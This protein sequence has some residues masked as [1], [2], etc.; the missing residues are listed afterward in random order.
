M[1]KIVLLLSVVL[2]VIPSSLLAKSFGSGIT[3]QEV[4]PI[5]AILDQPK[6]YVGKQ[7]K[8]AGL[9]VD[10]CAARGC[11]VYVAGER[12][13][14]KIRVKVVDG[15]I[16]FPM[17]ARGRQAEVE[18]IVEIFELSKEEVIEQRM[19]HALEQGEVFDPASVTEGE[20]VVR[21]RGLGAEIP[22]L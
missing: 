10:V 11:W 13:F 3:V 4:T 19:H 22:G 20:T 12:P 18:G 9:I 5:S 7:V 15:E 1:Q 21:L 16:V 8:V 14:D 17:E 2:L 6:E